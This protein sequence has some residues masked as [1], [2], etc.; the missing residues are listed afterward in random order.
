MAPVT[1]TAVA[2]TTATVATMTTVA[3][4]SNPG[5]SMLDLS[6]YPAPLNALITGGQKGAATSK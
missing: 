6:L 1:T 2:A 5:T 3:T 4:S